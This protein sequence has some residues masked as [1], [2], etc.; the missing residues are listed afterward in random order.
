MTLDTKSYIKIPTWII[1]IL[2]PFV[3]AGGG[4]YLA[5]QISLTKHEEKI[6]TLQ[7]DVTK[8]EEELKNKA[9]ASLFTTVQNQISDVKKYV[10]SVDGKVDR[11]ES[12]VDRLLLRSVPTASIT[13]GNKTTTN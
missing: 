2:L 4:T 7:R 1:T 11:V 9:D 8:Q 12:K 6:S 3:M 13:N 10:E 5:V